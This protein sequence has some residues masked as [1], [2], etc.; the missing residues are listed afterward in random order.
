[1][2][3]IIKEPNI[4]MKKNIPYKEWPEYVK[5]TTSFIKLNKSPW[6]SPKRARN[7]FFVFILLGF[8][9]ILPEIPFQLPNGPNKIDFHSNWKLFSLG[10]AIIV[11]SF[12]NLLITYNAVRWIHQN[13]TW[14]ERETNQ[15]ELKHK[16]FAIGIPLSILL[17]SLFLFGLLYS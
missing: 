10:I 7:F 2:S 14:D 16:I 17:I 5:I 8:S 6:N 15:S 12:Y 4:A 3:L 1:M 13:S 11:I 9:I